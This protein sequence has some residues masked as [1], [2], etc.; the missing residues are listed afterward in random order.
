MKQSRWAFGAWL[1]ALVLATVAFWIGCEQKGE[2]SPTSAGRRTLT[3]IDTL[4]VEPAIVAPG[5][6]AAIRARILNELNQPAV[7]EAVRFT[8]SRGLIAGASRGDTTV[9]SDTLGWATATWNAPMDTGA[10]LLRGELL[11]MSE[12]RSALVHVRA[13]GEG[14]GLLTVWAE[15][16]TLFA[17]NGTS[18][19][20]IYGRLRNS[21]NNPIAGAA[22]YF[23]TTIGAI[24]SPVVTDSL[25]GT[26]IATLTSTTE[27]GDAADHRH[28]GRRAGYHAGDVHRPGGRLAH[29]SQR[30]QSAAQCGYRQHADQ[31]LCLRPERPSD[32][33]QYGRLLQHHGGY[34]AATIRAHPRRR[35]R[36]DAERRAHRHRRHG[37]R[38]HRWWNCRQRDCEHDS[39]PRAGDPAF[40]RG[41][42]AARR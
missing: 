17:D 21:A 2:M 38:H 39:G 11:S 20:H 13:A 15:T 12:E 24:T 29:R 18:A 9:L 19:T 4:M 42:H 8:V 33:G 27:A 41:R 40:H 31:R 6:T 32:L 10:V 1:P 25:T 5:G 3:L 7:S 37:Q 23:S 22:I 26:A 16:D 36:H 35:G 14:E 34:A 28:V 30:A